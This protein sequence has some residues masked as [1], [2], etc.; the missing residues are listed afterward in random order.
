MIIVSNEKLNNITFNS[1]LSLMTYDQFKEK[2]FGDG[3]DNDNYIINVND[4]DTEMYDACKDISSFSYFTTNGNIP[5]FIDKKVEDYSKFAENTN[6]INNNNNNNNNNISNSN[7]VPNIDYNKYIVV[8]NEKLNYINKSMTYDQFK[9]KAFGEGLD[10]GEYAIN[11]K[12]IEEDVY[13]SCKD[14]D[15]FI[16]FST[17]ND[18]PSFIN[19][20]VQK[21]PKFI[22]NVNNENPNSQNNPI[23]NDINMNNMN[24]D[25]GN[26]DDSDPID[27]EL[28]NLINDSSEGNPDDQKD[29]RII[30][31]GSSKGGTGKTFTALISTYRYA[32]THP[33]QK[34]ALI[35]FD[36]IDG[37][38]GISIHRIKPTM[39]NYYGEYQKG[40]N[41]FKTL[42]NY[43]VQANNIFPQNVDFY[44]APSNGAVIQNDDF[45][46]NIIENCRKN[47]DVVVFDTGIDY[48][49]IKP[50][51]YSYKIADKIILVTTTS[52]KSVN[53][54]TKQISKLKGET[55]N[56]IF[57][58]DD[59]IASRLN[60]VITQMLPTNQMNKQIYKSL[61]EKANVI[62]TFGVI[63]DNI[64]RA[65]YFGEWNIFDKNKNICDALDNIMS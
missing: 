61:Q 31:F 3:L 5:S 63:T 49:N 50:I 4:I 13:D 57:D 19:S 1:A 35:D 18:I 2:A 40:Y 65:E 20:S 8:S 47:Y 15:T 6:T 12:D 51:S 64:S 30:V 29:A 55:K 39:R 34:I 33:H 62:A 54:V 28:L 37:Q 22:N 60:I 48:L 58:A 26:N 11:I 43:S 44:L 36:I 23:N 27:D 14:I 7:N 59:E 38:V 25:N 56:G 41:D 42:K 45:W 21:W 9:E 53:S 52:I 46:L 32:K 10:S 17:D 16:F 24:I